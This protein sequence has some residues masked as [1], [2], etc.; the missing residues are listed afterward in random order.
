MVGTNTIVI[1]NVA[2]S[3]VWL[4]LG[5][6][7]MGWSVQNSFEADD[8]LA[9]DLPDLRIFRS[10]RE[11]W[12]TPL[13]ENRDRLA[14]GNLAPL[15]RQW[16][17]PQLLISS[18]K[19][20]AGTLYS[21]GHHSACICWNTHRGWL[22]WDQQKN[23]PRSKLQKELL[24]NTAARLAENR[25]ETVEK[26]LATFNAELDAYNIT[27]AGETMKTSFDNFL[28]QLLHDQPLSGINSREYI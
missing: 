28:H 14:F 18:L 3:E 13:E 19:A 20:P 10:S 9:V 16:K 8:E 17:R 22:P 2:I 21:C 6:S 7:N 1:K 5:Q 27:D 25:G 12:H 11:H 26:A 23:D 4:C 15:S 24:E